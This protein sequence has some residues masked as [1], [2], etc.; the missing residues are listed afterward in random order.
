[1]VE[2]RGLTRPYSIDLLNYDI[3][4]LVQ[5]QQDLPTLRRSPTS[6][7][8]VVVLTLRTM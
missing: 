4:S 5:A 1:M 2:L 8:N 3:Y 7:R 6:K